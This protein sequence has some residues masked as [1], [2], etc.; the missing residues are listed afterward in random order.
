LYWL[1]TKRDQ[2][3]PQIVKNKIDRPPRKSS[4]LLGGL[5][6]NPL[7]SS[8]HDYYQKVKGCVVGFALQIRMPDLSRCEAAG[9]SNRQASSAYRSVAFIAKYA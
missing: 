9:V 3:G 2:P 8:L 1:A 4:D 6:G 7:V 5:G